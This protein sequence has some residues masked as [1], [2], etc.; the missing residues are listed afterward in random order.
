VLFSKPR[1]GLLEPDVVPPTL[2]LCGGTSEA[3]HDYFMGL[4]IFVGSFTTGFVVP[5]KL[6]CFG[7]W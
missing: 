1:L 4:I 6:F 7:R 2:V 3:K 5:T